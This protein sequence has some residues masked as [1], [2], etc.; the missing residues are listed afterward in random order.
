MKARSVLAVTAIFFSFLL[1][2]S[3]A[4]ALDPEKQPIYTN[5]AGGLLCG[6]HSPP[7]SPSPCTVPAGQRLIIEQAYA[8][9]LY[10]PAYQLGASKRLRGISWASYAKPNLYEASLEP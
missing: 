1:L 2:S 5:P 9:P 3:P 6:T 10:V 7:F 4:V 8:V